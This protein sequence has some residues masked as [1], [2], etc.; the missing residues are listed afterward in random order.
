MNKETLKNISIII[1]AIGLVASIIC[2]IWINNKYDENV[3]INKSTSDSLCTIIDL[4]K[5]T[6]DSLMKHNDSLYT[7]ELN[8]NDSLWQLLQTK[9]T[10]NK[11]K[12]TYIYKDS[13][14]IKEGENTQIETAIETKYID[15]IVE[16]EIVKVIHDTLQVSKIDTIYKENTT[17]LTK[18]D[19]EITKEVVVNEDLFNIYLD[20]DI[21]G[22]LDFDIIPEANV[23]IIIKEKYYG[24]I[25]I[26]YNNS[27]INP[28]AK[29]GIRL[30]VF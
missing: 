22:N 7:Y 13:T 9:Q 16:K 14:I 17:K 8:K 4:Q 20:A 23:G 10:T 3:Q 24:E 26:D 29:I 15:R 6:Y 25:G 12:I 2:N 19:E 28:N 21:K 5:N 11:T 30:N 27:K 1:L 18:Q